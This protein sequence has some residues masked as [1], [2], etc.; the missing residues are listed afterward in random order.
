[1]S[2]RHA[3]GEIRFATLARAAEGLTTWRP[4]ALGFVSLLIAAALIA[5]GQWIGLSMFSSAGAVL[6]MVFGLIAIIVLLAGSS[7]V[8]ALLMDKAQ[9]LPMRSFQEAA[10][11]GLLCIPKFLGFAL[12]VALLG[13]AFFVVAAVVYFVC[14][15]PVLGTVLAFVAHP[16]LIIVGA[17]LLVAAMGVVFPLFAPAVWS[18]LS[19]K[20]ALSNVVGIARKRLVPVVLM[21]LVLYV[22]V[23][24]IGGLLATGL[25]P[26]SLA[27]TGMAAGIIGNAG[28]IASYGGY[29]GYG[30]PNAFGMLSG[31]MGNLMGNGAMLGLSLGTALLGIVVMALM[32]QV[33]I[34][35]LNLVYLNAQDNLDTTDT[36]G[37]LDSF[38][39]DVRQR[40]GE[41]KERAMAAAERAR[42]VAAQ[43]AQEVAAANEARKA[44]AAEQARLLAETQSAEAAAR[45]EAEAEQAKQDAVRQQA[46]AQAAALAAQQQ[47]AV[48]AAQK[49]A[50]Q[51]AQ[52]QA[53]ADAAE[54]AARERAQAAEAEARQIAAAQAESIAAA[55]RNRLATEQ[56]AREQ[57]EQQA[58]QQRQAAAREA[59]AAQRAAAKEAER[60]RAQAQDDAAAA[61]A[62][63]ALP[64]SCPQCRNV[65]EVD[66]TFCSECGHKLK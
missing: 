25:V 14:K 66:D 27:L 23:G 31:F 57:A 58:E 6:G 33:M 56:A 61:Q 37:A 29:R 10:M 54:L 11:F 1:M 28:D 41:A 62:R 3:L 42:Q 22:I 16:V 34:L 32:A 51:E 17:V 24:I 60:Q 15:I 20:A 55:E 7:G 9:N 45:L 30:S 52:T 65:V 5:I 53:A 35:G 40:A 21:Q 43:K 63:A 64:L 59:E 13:I 8:G 36:E 18:G 2:E 19:M 46:L 48:D 4:L 49:A 26:S 47:A 50:E 12:L 44:A 38:L 39:G